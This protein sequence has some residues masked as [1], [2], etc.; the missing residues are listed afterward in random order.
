L[1]D[2]IEAEPKVELAYGS[3]PNF[4]KSTGK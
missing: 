1:A 2:T 4:P 3:I